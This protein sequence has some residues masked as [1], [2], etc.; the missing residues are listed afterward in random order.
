M[1]RTAARHLEG[2]RLALDDT[3]AGDEQQRSVADAHVA[4]RDRD[5]AAYPTTEAVVSARPAS[6]CWWL[7]STKPANSGCGLSGFDLNSGWN[8]TATYHGCD[9]QLDDLDELAVT[10]PADDVETA[11]GQRPFVAGS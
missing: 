9:G 2:V 10:R 1:S 3:R 8:C 6:L 11:L 7:A 5:H 4:D